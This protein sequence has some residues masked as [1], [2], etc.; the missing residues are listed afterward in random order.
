MS[1]KLWLASVVGMGAMILQLASVRAQSVIIPYQEYD[2]KIQAAQRVGPLEDGL[3][4]DSLSTYSGA[5]EFVQVDIDIPGNNALP[6]RLTRRL[7]VTTRGAGETIGGF[8]DWELDVPYVHAVVDGS[9][10]WTVA[11][12]NPNARCSSG[13]PPRISSYH[14]LDEV[15][16]GNQLHIP[17]AGDMELLKNDQ[18]KVPAVADGNT[19]PWITSNFYRVRCLAS[20]VNGYAGEGFLVLSPQGEKY[21]FNHGSHEL[22]STLGKGAAYPWETTERR[23]VYLRATR[24][25]DRFGNYVDYTYSGKLLT[26]ITASDGRQITF[27]YSGSKVAQASAHGRTWTYAYQAP[28]V[29]QSEILKTVTLPDASTWSFAWPGLPGTGAFEESFPSEE[30]RPDCPEQPGMGG[31][32][33]MT[34]KH[35][36]S[37]VGQFTFTAARHRRDGTPGMCIVR[38]VGYQFLTINNFFDN[39]A[40]TRKTISG[41]GVPLA[42]WD[43]DYESGSLHISP[44]AGDCMGCQ[45]TKDV[46]QTR[47]DGVKT[48]FT[49]GVTWGQNEGQLVRTEIRDAAGVV[50]KSVA[51]TYMP[52]SAVPPQPFAPSY[53][54][55]WLNNQDPLR[56]AIRPTTQ[57]VTTQ[58]GVNFTRQNQ[59]F[60]QF[61]NPTTVAK[62]STLGSRTDQLAYHH[63]LSKWVLGQVQTSTNVNTGLI[64]YRATFDPVMALTTE[65]RSFEKLKQTL[66]YN[67]NGTVATVKD[68][69]NNVVTLSSWKR[70]V[71]QGI[72][73][74]DSTSRS[75]V[76]DDWGSLT[77]TT[78]QNGFTTHYGYD[79]MGRLASIVYPTGDTTAWNTTTLN[80]QQVATAE[81]GI[82]AGHWRQTTT[83]GNGVKI[84]YLDALWRP[85]VTREYD[86]ANEAGTKRFQRFSYDA[87]GRTAFASYP[88]TTDAL[89]TG[90]WTAYDALGRPT[91]TSQD[92]ELSPSLLTTT[93]QYLTGFQQQVT[94]PR[95]FS[96]LT[97][98]QAFDVPTTD[99]PSGVTQFA[100]ADTSAT[101]IHRDIFG[102]PQRMRKRDATGSLFVDRHYVYDGNQQLCKAVEPETGA[103]IMDYDGA[104]NVQWSASGLH[105]LMGT[106]SCDT[107]AGRDSGRKVTRYYD[108]MNRL[109]SLH[110]PDGR[111]NQSWEY[112]LDGLPKK[113][114]TDNKGTGVDLV[115]N[116]YAYNKRRLL[117]SETVQHQGGSQWLISYGF[118]GNGSLASQSYPSGL[119]IS[120]A[121]NALGQAT[122]AS[123]QGG[124][125]YAH[126]AI[127]YPNGALK[128]FTYANG[129]VHSM[130][131]NAR[132][133]PSDVV[134]SGGVLHERYTY[135]QNGNV[136]SVLDVQDE[137]HL[138]WAVRNRW[139]GYDGLDRLTS[140]GSGSFGGDHWHRF[141]YDALDNMKSWKLAGVKDH[142][143][144]VYGVGNNRL[145]SIKNSSG[146]TTVGFGYDPQGNVENKN[147]V[148]HRFDYG[149]RLHEVVGKETYMYDGQGRR[150]VAVNGAGGIWT[151][152]SLSG[153][154][155]YIQSD[156]TGNKEENIYLAGSIVATRVW[157]A[158]TSYTA[159]FH[160][161]DALGSPIA[162]TN[163]AGVVIER[164]NYEPYGTVIGKPNYQG[165][166][167]TGH[168][169]DGATGLTYMQQ[170]Y[171]D[172]TVGRFLSV[173][174]VT[175]LSSPVGMFNRY[176]YAV[177]NPYRFV[178]PDGRQEKEERERRDM[179]SIAGHP[180]AGGMAISG[181]PERGGTADRP[182]RSEMMSR[183]VASPNQRDY[184]SSDP[185]YHDYKIGPVR[186]CTEM[187]TCT[188]SNL[189]K[190]VDQDSAPRFGSVQPGLNILHLNN[191]IM[192]SSFIGKDGA[193]YM[194]NVTT[195]D[196][197]FH[198]GAVVSR[199]F[200]SGGGV[201]LE[202]RG[203]GYS[204]GYGALVANYAIGYGY[205]AAWQ[206]NLVGAAK[207]ETGQMEPLK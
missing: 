174:P 179:R 112:W 190:T 161:T 71:P 101:E 10:G 32:M 122:Q 175:A 45:T 64:E 20:N 109:S 138:A 94:N 177:N 84:S 19:Y 132:Q 23:H 67:A 21:Y 33:T 192:H 102:K 60:D 26:A 11:G 28:S 199:L 78:D 198:A 96:T 53:G 194:V 43:Y 130:S 27:T 202:T 81:Y 188:V 37:A 146:A 6:V 3:F 127:Y 137:G 131:Q 59:A 193:F 85:V 58:D 79:A 187:G 155:T 34:M 173:D 91:S 48:Y 113:I 207:I 47:E 150:L 65:Q 22:A 145:E 143:E 142:A 30:E 158:A 86:A 1:R 24:V 176:K 93:I 8:A 18:A 103:T 61:A 90:N 55:S 184:D 203:F 126:G 197:D 36:S 69:K 166:G 121:P 95:G 178:D 170:R 123:D 87:R 54:T 108:S 5:T 56:S 72:Q 98:Y 77:S 117:D 148:I 2:K 124:Y 200:S 152:Y 12:S 7:N 4:G 165:I 80:F 181:L 156:R 41:P 144:Y 62:F 39:Y 40:L 110:F 89:T 49:Y 107:I 15:W 74:P 44:T 185:T 14:S 140:V 167:Y 50:K 149:N 154:Q 120:Y 118:D 164:N 73:Y 169:Q 111:G 83:T 66:A 153:Q 163:Q 125:S 182:S 201:Y 100:G 17:G 104:G 114:T 196:H 189:A 52:A 13:A 97:E 31:G 92:S 141:T 99:Y 139:M 9:L 63:N 88:G 82:P 46:V 151:Q 171:Y 70:G 57:I 195:S 162:V 135:D 106:T 183:P 186:L 134:S 105:A 136:A 42:T 25:E 116:Q 38:G 159:K 147:G 168:V 133:L 75:A 68:G 205:F 129:I 16:S 206:A 128:Q 115:Y 160:H 157:N 29:N 76:V 51:Q 119:A 191:P 172:P 180:G 35:P 204:S